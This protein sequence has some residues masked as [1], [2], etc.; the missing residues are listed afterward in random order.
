MVLVVRTTHDHH[1]HTNRTK[2][3]RTYEVYKATT[4][5]TMTHY[6]TAAVAEWLNSRQHWHTCMDEKVKV[7]FTLETGHK[8]PE[9]E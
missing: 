4:C 1:C 3:Y 9:R 8:G 6:D 5:N 7:K 2:S